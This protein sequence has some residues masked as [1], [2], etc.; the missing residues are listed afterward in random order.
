M[1]RR[2]D[3]RQ[4]SMPLERRDDPRYQAAEALAIDQSW[5]AFVALQDKIPKP[6]LIE[7][8]GAAVYFGGMS[9]RIGK[10]ALK[11]LGTVEPADRS[12]A[13]L[14]GEGMVLRHRRARPEILGETSVRAWACIHAHLDNWVGSKPGL[15][16]GRLTPEGLRNRLSAIDESRDSTANAEEYYPSLI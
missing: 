4:H 14:A 8:V 12:H 16:W 11:S 9:A 10:R 13:W 6:L 7:V 15:E 5:A 2:P 1:A 3:P